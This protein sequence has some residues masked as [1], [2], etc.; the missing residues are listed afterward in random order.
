MRDETAICDQQ[1]PVMSCIKHKSQICQMTCWLS[2]S[3]EMGR[4]C[5]VVDENQRANLR[6]YVDCM[7]AGPV[8][9]NDMLDFR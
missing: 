9:E 8:G 7:V 3:F 5:K 4:L 1:A 6:S 2:L